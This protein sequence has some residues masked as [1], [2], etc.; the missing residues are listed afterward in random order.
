MAASFAL[1]QRLVL[2]ESIPPPV[3]STY[4]RILVGIWIA[5]RLYQCFDDARSDHH[6]LGRSNKKGMPLIS[7]SAGIIR[8]FI[9]HTS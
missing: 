8:P 5:K 3:T 4:V 1:E 2:L 9:F 6:L 7:L